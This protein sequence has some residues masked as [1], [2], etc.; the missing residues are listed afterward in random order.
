MST[1]TFIWTDELATEWAGYL[2][3]KMI[4][5][6][7]QHI[8][9]ILAQWKQSKMP[10]QERINIS[11]LQV[12]DNFRGNGNDSFW[13]QFCSSKYLSISDCNKL[14]T[15]IENALNPTTDPHTEQSKSDVLFTTD[16]ITNQ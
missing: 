12:H 10:K 16:K 13:Y 11:R 14:S 1:E 2:E 6:S 7:I 8:P 9:Q 4:Y 3:S 15:D 5:S